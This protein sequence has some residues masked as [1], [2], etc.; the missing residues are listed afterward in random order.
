MTQIWL[1]VKMGF[2]NL[3]K[4]D[5]R[6]RIQDVV[7]LLD[8]A[9]MLVLAQPQGYRNST[10]ESTFR[11]DSLFFY[12][13]G[14]SETDAALLIRPKTND[15]SAEVV[16]FLRDKD[17][18]AELWNGA[19]LGVHKAKDQLPIDAAFS[20]DQLW[21]KLPEQLIGAKALH[22]SLGINSDN[23]R[24]VIECLRK[25]RLIGPRTNG[26]ILS[27]ADAQTI[28]GALRVVKRPE[29]VARMRA[30]ASVTKEAFKVVLSQ[31][32]PGLN[33]RDI[34]GI[35][36]GEFL[37]GGAEMEAYGSI[38]ARGSGA[39]CLHY[40]DNNRPLVGGELLLIDAGCQVDNYASDVTRTFP[41]NGTFTA[42]QQALYEVVLRSQKDAISLCR[43]GA[44]WQDIQNKSF[45]TLTEGLIEIGLIAVGV[46]EAVANN[47]HKK[48]CPHSISHWIGLDVHD[49]GVYAVDGKPVEFRAGMY[50]SVEPGIY[51][52]ADDDSVPAGFRGIGIRIE[53]DVLITTGGCE[54]LTQGIPKELAEVSK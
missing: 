1:G 30:A 34:H 32:R 37:K 14:F 40:R 28:S 46:D 24:K 47:L 19:R 31:L 29:E 4:V 53:D 51:I 9:A 16:L 8:G 6:E 3:P 36:L 18:V 54:V 21:L 17:P 11:Q 45:R 35:L 50:F 7:K 23:D 48:F 52:N 38:V 26:G 2:L 27:L 42:E 20:Y 43:P 49:A 10:V 12:L 41:I 44:T 15:N 39:C 22:F 33:E 5:Y 13:T 25:S